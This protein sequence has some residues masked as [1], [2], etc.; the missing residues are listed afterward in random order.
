MVFK[1]RYAKQDGTKEVLFESPL[2]KES[3]AKY[4]LGS[5][6]MRALQSPLNTNYPTVK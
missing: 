4:K 3:D 5:A 2:E 6:G 1:T